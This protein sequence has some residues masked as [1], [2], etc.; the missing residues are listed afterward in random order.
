MLSRPLRSIQTI[1]FRYFFI[2]IIVIVIVLDMFFIYQIRHTVEKDAHIYTYEIAKQVGRNMGYYVKHMEDIARLLKKDGEIRIELNEKSVLDE[3]RM[4]AYRN[5]NLARFKAMGSAEGD[6]ASIFV[7][8]KNGVI[9]ADNSQYM[10]KDYIDIEKTDWYT[11]AVMAKGEPVVSSPHIQNYLENNPKWVFSVSVAIMDREDVIG[12]ILIDMNYQ[13]ISDICSEIQLGESG[14]VYI[15][16]ANREIVYHPKQELIYSKL[17]KE[18][19][20][21]VFRQQ[22]GS[23]ISSQ[24][25][26]LITIHTI[27]GLEWKIVGVSYISELLFV[28][29]DLII[30]ILGF[31]GIC[32]L[33][34]FVVSRM[35]ARD[36]SRPI[37]ELQE[38]M[39]Q[40]EQG[41]MHIS[42]RSESAAQEIVSLSGSFKTMVRRIEQL[43]EEVKANQGKLRKSQFKVLQAQ[44]NPHFLYNTLDTIIWLGEKEEYERVVLMASALAKYFRLSLSKGE[45]IIPIRSEIDH[46]KNYLIIQKIR[47][48]NKL[49]YEF[50][51]DP[52]IGFYYTV[53]LILQPLVEN[54]LYHGI[55]DKDQGGTIR[56]SGK[57]IGDTI[58]FIVEDDGRGMTQDQVVNIF[59]KNMQ[60]SITTGGVAI[61][62]VHERLQIYFGKEYGLTYESTLGKGT[63]VY[64]CIPVKDEMGIEA[65]VKV[66]GR[67]T[68]E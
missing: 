16:N 18:D 15:V 68:Y 66:G 8:G 9:L 50:D 26:R 14:Y 51:I 45:D 30:V 22:E 54:A 53:K 24:D 58:C 1:I 11:K 12:V 17:K 38:A 55:K 25:K 36:I 40:V 7:F 20:H 21:G 63:R 2:L 65:V 57:R 34:T 52:E 47:Y 4:R 33:F 41:D 64:V 43:L 23:Y 13:T 49:R 35:I 37:R 46:V 3:E 60:Q 10:I 27:P 62:N 32:I 29:K 48:D 39:L 61:K 28:Q 56:I 6:V 59:K 44:I 67:D 19:I 5:E 42:I 31:T